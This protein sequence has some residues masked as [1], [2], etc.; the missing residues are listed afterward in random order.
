MSAKRKVTPAMSTAIAEGYERNISIAA[1]SEQF[2]V[3]QGAIRWH[4]LRNGAL[5][6]KQHWTKPPTRVAYSRASGPV[7]P[8]SAFEDEAIVRLSQTDLPRSVVAAMIG[9]RPNS[10][11]ARLH[12]LAR[13]D[14]MQ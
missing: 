1:M 13:R 5:R 8:F 4:A 9:R 7:R 2:G 11:L 3:S 10:V 14:A 6:P 12:A